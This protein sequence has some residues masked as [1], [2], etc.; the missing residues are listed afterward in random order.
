MIAIRI[1]ANVSKSI[2]FIYA[3]N[4]Q[5]EFEKQNKTKQNALLGWQDDSV[6]KGTCYQI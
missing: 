6:G 3:S 1:E 5:A 2:A 4:K